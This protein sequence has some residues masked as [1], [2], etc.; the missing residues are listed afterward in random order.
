MSHGDSAWIHPGLVPEAAAARTLGITPTTLRRQIERMG[1]QPDAST[2]TRRRFW[3]VRAL[4]RALDEAPAQDEEERAALHTALGRVDRHDARP[5]A[6]QIAD[7]LR[8]AITRGPLAG[9]TRLPSTGA[10]AGHYGVSENTVRR[11][12]R[13]LCAEGVV[14]RRAGSRVAVPAGVAVTTARDRA[15]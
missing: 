7:D 6:G 1:L 2:A 12:I 3:D 14:E 4:G 5:L 15:R 9:R 13:V 8:T 10:V 11:A